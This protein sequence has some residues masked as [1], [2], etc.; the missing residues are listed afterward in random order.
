MA[1]LCSGTTSLHTASAAGRSD[2]HDSAVHRKQ[3]HEA[4]PENKR[5]TGTKLPQSS[6]KPYHGAVRTQV[7]PQWFFAGEK[8]NQTE[9]R[10]RT[11][12]MDTALQATYLNVKIR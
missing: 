1:I 12:A 4:G 5:T 6:G 11:A 2:R 9:T 3:P 10:K 8:K 7:S